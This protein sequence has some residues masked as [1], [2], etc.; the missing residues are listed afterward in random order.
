VRSGCLYQSTPMLSID[1]AS[2]PPRKSRARR[3][4]EVA[5]KQRTAVF[6]SLGARRKKS[7]L[8]YFGHPRG[9]PSRP[10]QATLRVPRCRA[11][12]GP[13]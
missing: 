5:H 12:R 10:T 11:P 6:S 8:P 7:G 13:G 1:G 4:V 3:V 9:R 2:T